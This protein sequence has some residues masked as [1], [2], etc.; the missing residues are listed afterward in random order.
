MRWLS[1][2]YLCVSNQMKEWC[3]LMEDNEEA[4]LTWQAQ[5][6]L[7]TRLEHLIASDEREKWI[8][9]NQLALEF[10]SGMKRFFSE[11]VDLPESVANQVVADSERVMTAMSVLLTDMA[12]QKQE[13]AKEISG[14]VKGQK[15]INAYKKV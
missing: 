10:D 2:V 4:L 7:L 15:G 8:E 6:S 14:L 3:L 13:M 11:Y 12:Q 9:A 1:V 5:M